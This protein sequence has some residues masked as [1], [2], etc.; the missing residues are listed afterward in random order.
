MSLLDLYN[1]KARMILWADHVYGVISS[2]ITKDRWDVAISNYQILKAN[3]VDSTIGDDSLF[4]LVVAAD[5]TFN[6]SNVTSMPATV[7]SKHNNKTVITIG[8]IKVILGDDLYDKI[9]VGNTLDVTALILRYSNLGLNTINFSYLGSNVYKWLSETSKIP[10][11]ECF[12]S[13]FDN[14]LNDYCSIFPEDG[15]RGNFFNY[16]GTIT[17]SASPMLVIAYPPN[18]DMIVNYCVELLMRYV[19]TVGGS[20]AILFLGSPNYMLE[21]Q[22]GVTKNLLSEYVVYSFGVAPNIGEMNTALSHL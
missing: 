21:S 1:D 22:V 5:K 12:A 9:S 18:I 13:P 4:K 10:C 2:S 3:G 11:L 15:S 17:I 8:I 16:I 20:G 7:L 19:S 6:Y 14:T